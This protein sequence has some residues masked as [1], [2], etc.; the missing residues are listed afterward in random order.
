[1][2]QTDMKVTMVMTVVVVYELASMALHIHTY[3]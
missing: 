2:R 3:M 1:M